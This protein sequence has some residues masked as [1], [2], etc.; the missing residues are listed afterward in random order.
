[1]RVKSA[2]Y[3]RQRKKKVF[4]FAKGSYAS[5]K[6][7]WRIVKQQVAKSLAYSYIGRKDRKANF[8][9]LWIIRINAASR[10]FNMS[11]SSFILG[12]KVANIKLNRKLL[13]DIAVLDNTT[14]KQLINISKSSIVQ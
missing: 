1:M 2:V 7:R 13:S 14:F 11:Y 4:R 5:K 6:N 8:K 12:L 3:T 9:T 10:Q